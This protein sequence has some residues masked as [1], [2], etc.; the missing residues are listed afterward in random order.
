MEAG[1]FV[2]YRCHP[3]SPDLGVLHA[4]YRRH[5]FGRHAHPTYAIGVID[6]GSEELSYGEYAGAGDVV[7]INPETV[8]AG[9]A[10]TDEGWAYHVFYVPVE[11]VQSGFSKT[12]TLTRRIVDDPSARNA[13]R[14]AIRAIDED[15]CTADTLLSAALAN[16]FGRYGGLP[17]ER[18]PGVPVAVAARDIL[19]DEHRTPPSLGELAELL[20]TNRFA[21][22]RA[23]RDT[24]GLPPHAYLTQYR[25]RKAC[26]LIRRGAGLAG[27]AAAVGFV[28]QAHLSRHFRKT[29]GIT[30]GQYRRAVQERTRTAGRAPL[31]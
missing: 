15:V 24:Y 13:L 18:G 3:A 19:S 22:L 30:P 29:L 5:A 14:T 16:V 10:M 28:D 6:H 27:A 31:G 12:P 2:R 26:T 1:E 11:F 25:V 4:R 7:L 21:L 8:H 23:F 17:P 20:G 9:H